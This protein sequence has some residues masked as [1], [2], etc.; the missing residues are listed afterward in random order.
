M[1][2]AIIVDDEKMALEQLR[3]ALSQYKE[4]SIAAEFSD[5]VEVLGKIRV[6]KP[7]VAFLDIDMPEINGFMLAEEIR[8]ISP[9]TSIVF[10]TAYDD[11]AIKAFEINAVDYVLKP[12]SR[13]R[14]DNTIQRVIRKITGLE[15]K[16]IKGNDNLDKLIKQNI[17]RIL[18]WEG[19]NIKILKPSDVLF[20]SIAKRNTIIITKQ[21][22]YLG[23]HSLNYWEDRLAQWNFFR[24]HRSYLINLDKIEKI[25]SIFNNMYYLKMKDCKNEIPVSRRS[26]N[27]L[28]QI[29]GF[30]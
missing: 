15:G 30:D 9:G 14:I 8:D 6:L 27:N 12:I 3:Y 1:I 29:L 24:C 5:P 28:K 16:S 13:T 25:Y 19:E 2:R 4:I 23:K 7:D 11:Y 22:K 17:I 20:F 18:A 10:V 26:L 21:K